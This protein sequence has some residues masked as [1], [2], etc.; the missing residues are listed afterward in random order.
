AF[1][2]NGFDLY[3]L[4]STRGLYR[5][6]DLETSVDPPPAAL[7]TLSAYPNPFNPKTTLGFS[8]PAAGSARLEIFDAS[9]RRVAKIFDEPRPAGKQSADWNAEA[10]PSGVY[11]A[12]L[13]S[14]EFEASTGLVLLK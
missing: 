1:S 2:A 6:S 13:V 11:F 4:T 9:G 7:V 14:G 10:L 12:S 5:Y 8:L 3:V